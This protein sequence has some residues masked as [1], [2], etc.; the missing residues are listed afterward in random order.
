MLT[1]KACMTWYNMVI[2]S[3]PLRRRAAGQAGDRHGD[4]RG[5]PA[6]SGGT[7]E[8]FRAAVDAYLDH[9]GPEP[10]WKHWAFALLAVEHSAVTKSPPRCGNVTAD[11]TAA[12]VPPC[13]ECAARARRNAVWTGALP[14]GGDSWRCAAC[15][16]KWS[17]PG[18]SRDRHRR[19]RGGRHRRRVLPA[20]G[21][22]AVPA[23]VR[24]WQAGTAGQGQRRPAPPGPRPRAG[25]PGSER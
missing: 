25:Q 12:A 13:P 5:G 9:G 24:A 15:G 2:P 18:A 8:A 23:G 19:L 21:N 16:S 1:A 7:A 14:D 3:L 11:V 4:R 22:R 20:L 10:D 6:V 17:T